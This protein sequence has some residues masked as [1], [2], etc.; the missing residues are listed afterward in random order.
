M[1]EPSTSHDGERAAGAARAAFA[2]EEPGPGVRLRRITRGL[3]SPPGSRAYK[4]AVLEAQRLSAPLLALVLPLLLLLL[5]LR[6]ELVE[7]GAR[8]IPVAIAQAQVAPDLEEPP[9]PLELLP[10]FEPPSLAD[11][12][13]VRPD[14]PAV[15]EPREA[16]PAAP[17]L[18]S[19]AD[20]AVIRSPIM[21]RG[22]YS[23]RTD[24]GMAEG[25]RRHA[26]R[27]GQATEASVR[28]ALEWL[29]NNQLDDGSWQGEGV[30]A[31]KAA[32]TGLG[33]LTFLAHNETPGSGR[34][35][36]TV[37]RAIEFLLSIQLPD[38]TF[39]HT[40]R[41]PRGGVYAHGIASYALSEAYA[42]TRIP[43]IRPA[44]ERAIGHIVNGQ[45]PDGGFDYAFV[46]GGGER[47]RCTSV[48][49]WMAQAMKAAQM[50]GAEV[51]GL[52]EALRLAAEGFRLQALDDGRFL[53]SS[54]SGRAFRSMIPIGTLCLQLLGHGRSGE[55]R[56]GLQAMSDWRPDWSN[57]EDLGFLEPLYVWYYATQAFFHQGGAAWERWNDA[58]APVLTRNQN[59]DGSWSWE[60]GRSAAY[61]PV[62][63][64]T[65][66]ALGLMVYYRY[67]PTYQTPE[68]LDLPVV[69]DREDVPVQIQF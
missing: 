3:K 39:R 11:L 45:R 10:A 18:Q 62:Y 14:L 24:E 51:E 61:G 6:I 7:Q 50:A 2:L 4:L 36:E 17:A 12:A 23:S 48:A 42:L 8:D 46:R 37:R 63:A 13:A 20:V 16:P 59:E 55:V 1:N 33:L 49:G 15:T 57:P 67:L 44:V 29:K 27:H 19:F 41:G 26:G 52:D 9:E 68:I 47:D 58:F 25:L 69:D 43:M 65:L 28:R 53:Y 34:Y 64:T 21:L 60:H 32:M 54:Q 5:L 38:G 40:E 30:A 31:S 35:G 66:N 56:G 22:L